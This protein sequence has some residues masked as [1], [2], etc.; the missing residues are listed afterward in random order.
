[1]NWL[2]SRNKVSYGYTWLNTAGCWVQ[3]AMKEYPVDLLGMMFD[4]LC[5]VIVL[6]EVKELG[7]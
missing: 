3:K 5:K 6:F 7:F 2:M 1:M 4:I